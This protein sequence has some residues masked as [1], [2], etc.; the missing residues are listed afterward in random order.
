MH[1]LDT[2][3]WRCD[4]TKAFHVFIWCLISFQVFLLE[5]ALDPAI[6]QQAIARVHRIG[7]QRPVH[8]VRLL[9]KDTVEVWFLM[10]SNFS[11]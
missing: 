8:I 5:P 11:F 3:Y 9:I 4:P 2:L 6:E 10:P 1:G 7:Q